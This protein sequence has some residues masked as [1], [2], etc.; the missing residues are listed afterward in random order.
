VRD[1]ARTRY[2]LPSSS[3]GTRLELNWSRT[4]RIRRAGG[5]FLAGGCDRG[6]SGRPQTR[7]S[8]RFGWSIAAVIRR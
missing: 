1:R 8:G 5:L 6:V 7:H 4:S 3:S 2:F